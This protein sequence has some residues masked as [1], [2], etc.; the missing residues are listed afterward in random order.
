MTAPF[1]LTHRQ[2]AALRYITGYQVAHGGVSPSCAEIAVGIGLTSKGSVVRLLTQI[3]ERGTIRR[4]PYKERAID[5]VI[6]PAV[7]RAPDGAPLHQVFI[8]GLD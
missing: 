6:V 3:E 5:L 4:L 8:E 7:P 1:P 2:M